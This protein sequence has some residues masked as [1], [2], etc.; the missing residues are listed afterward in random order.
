MESS[1]L[2]TSLD[3]WNGNSQLLSSNVLCTSGCTLVANSQGL[4]YSDADIADFEERLER[5]YTREIHMVQVVDFQGMPELLRNGLFARMA[6]EH[7][8]EAVSVRWSQ[9]TTELE[10]VY[11]GLGITHR[12][13]DGVPSFASIAGRSQAPEKVTVTDLFYL[14]GLDVRS[15]NIPYLLARYLRRFAAG[16]KNGAHISSEQFVGKLAYHFRL[17]TAKILLGLIVVAT[18]LPMIDMVELVRLQIYVQLDDTWAWVAMRPERQPDVAVGTPEVAQD[19]LIIDEVGQADPI[20]VRAPP[21]PPPA[22]AWTMPQ[23]MARLEEDVYEIC[24]VLTEQREVI[25]AMAYDFSRF[26]TWVT[27]GLGRMMDRAG[28][29]GGQSPRVPV[30]FF[31]DP[32]EAIRHAYLVETETPKSPYTVA[33]PTSLLDSTPPTCHV[34]DSMDS[35]TSIA[36]PMSSDFTAPLSPDHLLTHA[37]P[38]LVPFLHRTTRMAVRVPPTM[39]HGLSASIAEVAAMSDSAFHKR[40]RSSYES[41]PSSSPP[42]LP[43]RK[44]YRGT[45]ELVEDDEEEDDDEDEDE[46]IDKSLD[47]N[48]ESKDVEDKG[49]TIE[50]KDPATGDKGLAVGDEGL[51]IRV[52]SL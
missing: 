23:R 16:R 37:L 32:Y 47:S 48:S 41:S 15:V 12:G 20:L 13:G 2:M 51:D 25:D 42:D 6:M 45:T 14:R 17:L 44:C 8:D 21:P 5:I 39:S 52:E 3:L 9:E 18:K 38:T 1:G 36:R 34:E 11:S 27:T 7:R 35:D 43:S 33:S 26:S 28:A 19:A 30:P 40:F 10:A 46:G 22:A 4:E 49:P 24:E 31:K 50:D 29:D